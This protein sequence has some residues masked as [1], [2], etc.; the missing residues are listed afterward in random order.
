MIIITNNRLVEKSVSDLKEHEVIFVDGSVKNV[1]FDARDRVLKNMELATDPLG[2]RKVRA[3][4]YLSVGLDVREEEFD[5]YH[6]TRLEQM[7]DIYYKNKESFESMS[8]ELKNDFA[9]L[10][11]SL[12]LTALD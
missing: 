6:V 1:V 11:Q 10:D 3:N 12:I 8:S 2:G 4:P 7:L 5:S 9:V